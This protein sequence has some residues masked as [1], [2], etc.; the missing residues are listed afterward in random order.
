VEH[1]TDLPADGTAQLFE[2]AKQAG[3]AITAVTGAVRINYAVLGNAEP[4]LHVHLI[5]RYPGEPAPTR[6]PWSDPRPAHRLEQAAANA[7][8]DKIASALEPPH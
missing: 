1:L 6:P 7:L 8:R 4:H 3:R 2:D 5:P